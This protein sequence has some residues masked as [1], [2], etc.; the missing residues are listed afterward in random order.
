MADGPRGL[1]LFG[2]LLSY[3][4]RK[5]Q[6]LQACADRYGDVV[7]LRLGEPTWLLNNAE[8]IHR[9]LIANSSNY[10][11]TRRLTSQRENT[12][13]CLPRNGVSLQVSNPAND[14]WR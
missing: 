4:P 2:N 6:Y 11:K 10:Q 1:P 7:R 14:L 3:L 8:D 12:R 5:L 9:V 13:R